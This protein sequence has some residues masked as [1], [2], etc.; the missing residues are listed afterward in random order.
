MPLD[1]SAD[2]LSLEAFADA[3]RVAA[4]ESESFSFDVAAMY[5]AQP[6]G[7]PSVR[8]DRQARE[9]AQVAR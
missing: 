4:L 3:I 2:L 9:Y 6:A 5:P 1:L 8:G 7:A